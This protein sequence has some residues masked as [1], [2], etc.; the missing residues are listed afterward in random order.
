MSEIHIPDPAIRKVLEQNEGTEMFLEINRLKQEI[1]ELTNETRKSIGRHRMP[2]KQ[3]AEEYNDLQQRATDLNQRIDNI[4]NEELPKKIG[5][6]VKSAVK[7]RSREDDVSTEQLQEAG[8]KITKSATEQM[9][10]ILDRLI[11]RLEMAR[12]KCLEK[13]GQTLISRTQSD[14]W[15]EKFT[16]ELNKSGKLFQNSDDRGRPEIDP[17]EEEHGENYAAHVRPKL[18]QFYP[19]K[20]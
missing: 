2:F 19:V 15:K 12:E 9:D 20:N 17:W 10:E 14:A 7:K 16:K 1:E 8:E 4:L 18:T 11:F 6:A 5:R 13:K 3:S